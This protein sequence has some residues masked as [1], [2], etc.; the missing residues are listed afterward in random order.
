VTNGNIHGDPDRGEQ[1]IDGHKPTVNSAKRRYN[2][3]DTG[4]RI[5]VMEQDG[6]AEISRLRIDTRADVCYN[7]GIVNRR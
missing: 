1:D 4:K 6:R 7:Y 2:D 5:C 3:G